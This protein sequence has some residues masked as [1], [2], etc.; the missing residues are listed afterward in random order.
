MHT[1]S[2][3]LGTKQAYCLVGSVAHT[4]GTASLAF[5]EGLGQLAAALIARL[6]LWN[7]LML[8]DGWSSSSVSKL[9]CSPGRSSGQHV[10]DSRLA[11]QDS[12]P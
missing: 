3:A 4:A 6:L 1:P 5:W 8:F 11:A 7:Y 2:T 12:P 10:V 9:S